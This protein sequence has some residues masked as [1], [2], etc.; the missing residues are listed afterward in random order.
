[1]SLPDDFFKQVHG[2]ISLPE[3]ELNNRLASAVPNCGNND[4]IEACQGKT[5][6]ACG[7]IR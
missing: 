2:F 5:T 1:M 3:R 4:E 7:L 6:V